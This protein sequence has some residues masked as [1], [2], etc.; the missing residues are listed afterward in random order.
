MAYYHNK[1]RLTNKL[2][3][4]FKPNSIKSVRLHKQ[5]AKNRPP[6]HS[7]KINNENMPHGYMKAFIQRIRERNLW[8]NLP[9]D[10]TEVWE[11]L[12]EFHANPYS[13]GMCK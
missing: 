11:K 12:N 3:T 5:Q 7:D 10:S 6:L 13:N 4:S 9:T 2:T 8:G 1:R